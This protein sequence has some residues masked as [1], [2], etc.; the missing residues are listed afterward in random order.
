MQTVSSSHHQEKTPEVTGVQFS[1]E[2]VGG[3]PVLARGL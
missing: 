2:H 1:I 3:L